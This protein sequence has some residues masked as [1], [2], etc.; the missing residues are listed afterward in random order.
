MFIY[1]THPVSF[2]FVDEMPIDPNLLIG[3]KQQAALFLGVLSKSAMPSKK[4]SQPYY[5]RVGSYLRR[6]S[7]QKL[8]TLRQAARMI[9]VSYDRL[10]YACIT[11]KINAAYQAEGTRLFTCQ[12][13]ENARTYFAHKKGGSMK[14]PFGKHKGM[15][16]HQLPK[17]YLL[18]LHDNCDLRGRLRDEIDFTLGGKRM[19]DP[20]S[21]ASAR[22]T[23]PIEYHLRPDVLDRIA[24]DVEASRQRRTKPDIS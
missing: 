9:G 13:T 1:P 8:M 19:V 14:M 7:M 2:D 10:W 24:A 17:G 3:I 20:S 15:P 5:I 21:S 11:K 22:R 18:W 23:Q 6:L 4:L 16:V 12:D